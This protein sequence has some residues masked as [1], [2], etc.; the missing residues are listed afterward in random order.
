MLGRISGAMRINFYRTLT[1]AG[2]LIV[3]LAIVTVL[4]PVAL[5]ET[6][7]DG[8]MNGVIAEQRT[9]GVGSEDGRSSEGEVSANKSHD[10]NEENIISQDAFNDEGKPSSETDL[11]SKDQTEAVKSSGLVKVGDRY[12]YLNSDGT[13]AK[14]EWKT[15]SGK[16]YYFESDGYAARWE[17]VI[18]GERYYFD[19][20]GVM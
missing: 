5:A 13:Y 11:P 16:R 4:A 15:I 9:A 20:S 8:G 10:I 17:T 3:L 1:R 2:V 19:G 6:S 7:D 18:G 12:K 14:D